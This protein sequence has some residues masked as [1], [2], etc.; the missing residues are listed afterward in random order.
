[1]R[2]AA[3]GEEAIESLRDYPADLVLLDMIMAPGIS[4]RETYERMLKLNPDQKAII[5]SGFAETEDVK[6]TLSLGASHF[7]KKP[8]KIQDLGVAI[9][10]ALTAGITRS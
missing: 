1:M 8:L 3:S 5:I 7:L 9:R 10:D 2:S 6:I 4:G